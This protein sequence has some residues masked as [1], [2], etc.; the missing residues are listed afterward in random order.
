MAKIILTQEVNGLGA[1]GDVVDVKNGYAR[2][3]LLPRGFAVVWTKGG[4][5]QVESIRQARAARAQNNLEDAQVQ[6]E[7]LSAAVVSVPV[8]AG[9][10][11]RLFGTVKPASIAEAIEAAGLGSVDK[12]A[13]T[14]QNNIKKTGRHTVAVRLHEDVVASVELDVVAS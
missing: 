8:K 14:I 13:V 3:Y 5:R 7:K 10:E 1:A 11:G 2:N 6:A 12:R 4:E 9:A